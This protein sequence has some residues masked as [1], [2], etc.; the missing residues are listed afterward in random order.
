MLPS[1]AALVREGGARRLVLL[2]DD[3]HLLDDVSATL[4][5]QLVRAHAVFVIATEPPRGVAVWE[6]AS[7]AQ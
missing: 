5:Y 6:P 1:S 3:A 7:T 4:V 2:V